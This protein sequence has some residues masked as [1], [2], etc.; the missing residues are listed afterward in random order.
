MRQRDIYWADLE[1]TF[2]Q[3]QQGYRPV[4]IISGD[5]MN[6]KL[7]LRI[8]CPLSSK[9]KNLKGCVILKK[10]KLN[11]LETD[12]E[13]LPFQVRSI[14]TSRLKTKI[15]EINIDELERIKVGL[16]EMLTL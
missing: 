13:V 1:P 6:K 7:N 12:S 10:N 15:G 8:I 14:T 5:T 9:V 2:G 4:L 3:E 11:N 16:F